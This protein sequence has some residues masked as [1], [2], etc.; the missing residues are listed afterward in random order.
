VL[1]TPKRKKKY[2]VT[3]LPKGAFLGE[4]TQRWSWLRA[5]VSS[6]FYFL[7]CH[8]PCFHLLPLLTV[9]AKAHHLQTADQILSVAKDEIVTSYDSLAEMKTALGVQDDL[10]AWLDLPSKSKSKSKTSGP[11][12]KTPSPTKP[13]K[14]KQKEKEKEKEK[15]RRTGDI[16]SYSTYG[17]SMGYWRALLFLGIAV[18]FA[19]FSKFSS[20]NTSATLSLSLSL[21]L[22]L[23]VF[24]SWVDNI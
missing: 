7:S 16:K 18:L 4:E 10:D 2:S 8:N 24:L 21:S 5:L 3:S 17:R 1:S 14:L 23:L 15:V 12:K 22:S 20:K 11:I 9:E 19:F 6:N 13:A